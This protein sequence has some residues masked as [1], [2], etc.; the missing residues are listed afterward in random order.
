[1]TEPLLKISYFPPM[2]AQMVKVG[3]QTGAVDQML[4]K[5]ADVFEEEV[6]E[7]MENMTKMIEPLILVVLGGFVAVILVAMYLP[8]FMAAG[9]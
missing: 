7:L 3:E 1:M 8:I 4:L 5:I 2:V 9:G 6:S